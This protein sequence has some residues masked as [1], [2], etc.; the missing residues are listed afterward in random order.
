MI[1][2]ML[3]TV[4]CSSSSEFPNFSCFGGGDGKIL[5]PYISLSD[6]AI[7]KSMCIQENENGC[8][9]LDDGKCYW[10]KDAITGISNSGTSSSCSKGTYL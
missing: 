2:L 6:F 5:G 1:L 9:L 8:C 10:V 3:A 4:R 7:C